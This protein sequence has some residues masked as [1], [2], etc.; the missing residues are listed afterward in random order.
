MSDKSFGLEQMRSWLAD[1]P[2]SVD[3]TQADQD[4][5]CRR[6]AEEM[7]QRFPAEEDLRLLEDRSVD[8]PVLVRLAVKLAQSKR[9]MM[10][11]G[12]EVHVS[13][14]FAVY[15]EH[16]RLR[17]QAEHPHG[18]DFLVRKVEQIEWLLRGS[19]GARWEML[20]VDDGC[21]E[22][23]GAIAQD[24]IKSRGLG[25]RVK[26]LF[27]QHAIDTGHPAAV[28]I[29]TTAD[30][31]KGGSIEYGMSVATEDDR[32]NH[33]V[34]FTDADLSTH[35]GQ[36]GLLVEPIL[37]R[38]YDA[39]I[40]SRREPR[41]VVIKSGARNARGKL[42]IYLWKRLIPTLSPIIDTQCG[43]KAFRADVAAGIVRDTVEKRFA[44]DIELLLRTVLG[45]SDSIERVAIAW[46]DSEAA[47]TT[48]ELQPYLPMLKSLVCISE[49]YL[50]PN[51][52][53]AGFS[54]LIDSLDEEAWARLSSN[55]PLEI[56]EREPIEFD[57]YDEV[58][59]EHLRAAARP[60]R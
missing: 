15:K 40:G 44:F 3:L 28:G 26:V 57:D 19:S 54:A 29:T 20:V 21:P 13:V 24:V 23:S 33:V 56:A 2:L 47:S 52:T 50:P 34:V 45:R 27:L 16:N 35:L 49:K 14:V 8:A 60:T 46:I 17:T 42:F 30:S 22:N 36:L 51:E 10:A 37:G 31:Q 55:V 4:Q 6:V 39:A 18:E 48:T 59:P 43:F 38:G 25:D 7:L 41:S 11:L 9:R 12:G 5:W 58:T 32:R 1:A 53:A